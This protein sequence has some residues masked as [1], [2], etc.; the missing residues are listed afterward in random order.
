M[1]KRDHYR[2]V[3][4]DFDPAKVARMTPARIEKILT[5]PRHRAQPRES[6][7]HGQQREGFSEDSE[8]VRL[9]R[10]IRLELRRRKD[11]STIASNV[12]RTF[13]AE[14]EESRALSKDLVKRGLPLR[15][16]DDHVRV[17]AGN[18][19]GERSYCRLP[20]ACSRLPLV[21]PRATTPTAYRPLQTIMDRDDDRIASDARTRSMARRTRAV[22]RRAACTASPTIRD[23]SSQLRDA[24]ARA[25]GQRD[26]AAHAA[27]R[28]CRSHD[29]RTQVADGRDAAGMLVSNPSMRRRGWA[30]GSPCAGISMGGSISAHLGQYRA[31]VAT[32]MPI[33]PDF[34]LLQ[35]AALGFTMCSRRSCSR[36]PI[37]SCGG[38][39][40]PK[41]NQRPKTAYP[42]FS[43]HALMQTV[44][45]GSAVYHAANREPARTGRIA[46]VVNTRTIRP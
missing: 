36:S 4:Y 28:L 44:R 16:P 40:A 22:E 17:H 42:R 21:R 15:R 10:H 24:T 31:D 19:P 41:E 18:G 9:V 37:F 7:I 46:T 45:I 1:R 2:K 35:S 5:R 20:G 39:L 33:A 38:I 12:V 6:R 26:R 43:T 11:A 3:F 8:R 25:R 32:S 14:S 23:S 34:G 30:N 27:A 13:P 29:R